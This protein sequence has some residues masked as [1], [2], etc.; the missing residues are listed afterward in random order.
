M[1]GVLNRLP[2]WLLDRFVPRISARAS[3]CTW[4]CF[5]PCGGGGLRPCCCR[6]GVIVQCA[7]GCI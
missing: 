7:S 3:H 2:D 4:S 6:N 5:L 1:S